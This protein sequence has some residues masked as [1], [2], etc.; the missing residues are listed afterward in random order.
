MPDEARFGCRARLQRLAAMGHAVRRPTAA[1]LRDGIYE[2][3]VRAGRVHLRVLYFFH[4]RQAIVV[5][6]GF[7]KKGAGVPTI[8]IE[9]ALQ[10]KQR[11]EAEPERHSGAEVP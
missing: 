6:H 1:Y 5:T 7:V 4:G 11:F 3:R 2:L 10:R 9:R 8:E